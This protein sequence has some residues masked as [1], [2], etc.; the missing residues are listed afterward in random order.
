MHRFRNTY[1]AFVGLLEQSYKNETAS[2]VRRMEQAQ[3]F[4]TQNSSIL[5]TV[6]FIV[7]ILI[8][9]YVVY[10]YLYPADDPTYTQFLKGEAD[11]RSP[12]TLDKKKVPAI[13]TGG[14]FT[15]SFWVYIDD[16]NYKASMYKF[17]FA[18][19]PEL[20]GPTSVSPLVG[21]LTPLRNSLMVRAATV[22][23]GTTPAPGSAPS[24]MVG[25]TAPDVNTESNLQNLLN[26]RTS[27]M[28]S[29]STVEA[30]CDIKEVPL[31]RWVCVTIVSSGRVLDIYMDGK[32]ARSCVLDNVLQVP[33][34]PLVLR[35][36]DFGGRYSS[37]Q[38]W[39]AQLTPDVIYGI[40][41]MGPT[42][43]QHNIFTDIAKYLN[44]NVSFTGSA[45]GQPIMSQAS[46]D[47]FS[48]LYGQVNQGYNSVANTY[49][50]GGL[51]GLAGSATAGVGAGLGG[52]QQSAIDAG[53]GLAARF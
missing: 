16:W 47:P 48:Q 19:S 26:Q 14:D 6:A 31:Q 27:M 29:E 21:F 38:M 42:Q 5:S 17:L 15:L 32:L 12:I 23:G 36:G 53:T 34:G 52:L 3:Q 1:I 33:R 51:A 10:T 4:V 13:Y 37:V 46:M 49:Q 43:T 20:L 40:Y 39:S 7:V 9:L 50:S 8:I 44:L 11:A 25:S 24:A 2:Y 30:P 18:L 22:K 41:Q 35:L 45:P 28:M